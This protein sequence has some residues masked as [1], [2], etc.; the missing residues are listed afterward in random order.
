MRIL[1]VIHGF[2]P[3]YMAGSEV[4]AYTLASEL[5]KNHKVYVFSR[6]ENPFLQEYDIVRSN[7]G[8]I[9]VIRVNKP[10]MDY[11][12]RDKY[13]DERMDDVYR[14]IIE[15][16]DPDVVHIHHL[17]HLSTN[18]VNIT[19][20][21]YEKPVIF[22]IH[23]FWM[24]CVR[25]QL[26]TKE[27][28]ICS[29]PGVDR[30][31][32]CL[33][34][35]HTNKDEISE[36]RKHM[37]RVLK[38]IDVFLAPSRFIRTFYINMKVPSS[39]VLYFPYGFDKSKIKY[40][41]KKYERD[42][43]ITFGFVGRITP[44]KG[45]HILI[46]AFSSIE[47]KR[48]ASLKIYGDAGKY[49]IYLS[50]LGDEDV[51]FMGGFDNK[52]IDRVLDNIDILVVPSIWYENSPL[53]IQE[54]FLKGIPVITSNIGGMKELVDD[55]VDGFLFNV[56]DEKSLKKILEKVIKNPEML[57]KIRGNREKVRDIQDDAAKLTELFRRVMHETTT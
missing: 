43:K 11:S 53:V 32:T 1:E 40:R 52:E 28:R 17:S 39:K 2:P 51:Y 45:V 54:A 37:Q 35:L 10:K 38:N 5:S 12:L 14:E 46:R 49:R 16:I 9:N 20:E 41:K 30:C 56:G 29:G 57:N 15:D 13:M 25:G 19:K 36:Y 55:G 31:L 8:D 47:E 24:F 44:P 33:S 27:Y 4:Y 3:Y 21:E 42:S 18:I 22:T 48:G 26:L 50:E 6:I 34:Y 23:D 7:M